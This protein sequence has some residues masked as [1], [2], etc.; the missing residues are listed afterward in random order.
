MVS[1]K[2]VAKAAGV[3]TATVSRVIS[4]GDHVRPEVRKRV[5]DAVEQLGYRPNLLARSL[6]SQQSKTIGLIVSD[7]RNPFFTAISRAVEDTAYEQGYSLF[8]CNTDEDPE[9]ETIYLNLMQDENVAG[10]IF[11]PTRQTAARF[12]SLHLPF[13]TVIVDRSV[14]DAEVDVVL[15][16]N[17]DAA[18]RLTLHLLEQGFVRIAALCGEMS[19][20]G[21]ERYAGYEKALR[22]RD[23]AIQPDLVKFIQPRIEAGYA[24]TQK[25]LGT[26]LP[27]DAILTTNSL[28]AAGALQ[29]IRE[30][31]LAIPNDIALVSFDETTWASLVQPPL[32]LIAQP[33]HEIGK[34]A[35]ELLLERIA[36]PT[37][38]TRQ[39]MLKGQLLE[40]GS[41]SLRARVFDNQPAS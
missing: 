16:D 41:S 37:R 40:R 7:I 6:R 17:I 36:E 5:M 11:S 21:R 31:N 27:P 2:D 20:T 39:V 9:K 33:T 14:G 10:V 38:P 23:V 28:I 13:P 4:N 26:T 12:A 18:Y 35:T 8:L 3:S 19:T 34:T 24:A 22:A 32:T 29:A 1:I 15:L 30:H 25:L